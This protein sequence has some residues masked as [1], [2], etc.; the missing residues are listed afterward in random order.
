[1]LGIN[2]S[3]WKLTLQEFDPIDIP[4]KLAQELSSVQLFEEMIPVASWQADVPEK[5]M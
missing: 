1:M 3:E 5:Q 2:K 4:P